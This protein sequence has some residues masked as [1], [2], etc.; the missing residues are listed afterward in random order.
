MCIGGVCV[1]YCLDF[2]ATCHLRADANAHWIF[3]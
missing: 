3:F 1:F 2:S